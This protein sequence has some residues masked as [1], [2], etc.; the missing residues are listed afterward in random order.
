MESTHPIL[1]KLQF[2]DAGQ[3]VLI[4]GAPKSYKVVI[5][6]FSGRVDTQISEE[7]YDFIQIFGTSNDEIQV[8]AKEAIKHVNDQGLVWLCYPK[9]SSKTYKESDCR[10]DTVAPLLADDGYEPVRQV[11]IDEVW[12]ALRFRKVEQIKKMTRNFAYTEKGI[13]KTNKRV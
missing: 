4:L 12:S 5:E 6:G 2:K 1:K 8:L 10:R 9:K 13:E 3:P 11:A 7:A